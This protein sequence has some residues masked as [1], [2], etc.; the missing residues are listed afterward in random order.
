MIDVRSKRWSRLQNRKNS[1]F[2]EDSTL[3]V[4]QPLDKG[5]EEH[6][7]VSKKDDDAAIPTHLWLQWL[8]DGDSKVIT[9]DQ[10]DKFILVLQ[11]QFL[12]LRWRWNLTRSIWK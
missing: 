10:W 9:V 3:D 7:K 11:D 6:P 12:L 4:E 8:N 5:L 1:I 2:D